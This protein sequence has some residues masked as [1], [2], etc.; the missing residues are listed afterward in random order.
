MSPLI[1]LLVIEALSRMVNQAVD[2]GSFQG[3]KVALGTLISHLLFVDDVLILGSGNIDYWKALKVILSK[4]CEA[5]GL[6]INLH[7]SVFIAQNIDPILRR[8][9]LSKFKIQIESLDQGVKYLGFSLKPNCYRISDWTWII[10]KIEKKI[11]NWTFR[12]LSLGGR[13]TLATSVLQ[14]IPNYCLSL[15]KSLMS[16]LQRSQLLISRFI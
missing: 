2:L 1:F 5:T 7:K 13:L 9:L 11:G 14:S 8:F 15:A 12:W 4:F 10:K 3:L 16:I 6:S